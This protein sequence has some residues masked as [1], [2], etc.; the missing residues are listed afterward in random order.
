M[1]FSLILY[2]YN[3]AL[4]RGRK[5][6][7]LSIAIMTIW[8]A[9]CV[10]VFKIVDLS[11]N[12][13]DLNASIHVDF[14]W[15]VFSSWGIVIFITLIGAVFHGFHASNAE[16][17]NA[18]AIID[19]L[20]ISEDKD[21]NKKLTSLNNIASELERYCI[22]ASALNLI[23]FMLIFFSFLHGYLSI[24]EIIQGL[25]ESNYLALIV[26]SVFILAFVA[27]YHDVIVFLNDRKRKRNK[28]KV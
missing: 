26:V 11:F 1:N 25:R 17:K 18:N 24:G 20:F 19:D 2:R 3:T 7:Q 21:M 10:F 4:D 14:D 16:L 15:D 28:E 5:T 8:M 27:Y 9:L 13:G 22:K 6:V 23:S 12:K